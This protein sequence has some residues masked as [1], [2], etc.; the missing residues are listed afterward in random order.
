MKCSG[1]ASRQVASGQVASA[2]AIDAAKYKPAVSPTG[3]QL[4]RNERIAKRIFRMARFPFGASNVLSLAR[5]VNRRRRYLPGRASPAGVAA[6]RRVTC[7]VFGRGGESSEIGGRRSSRSS[8][9]GYIRPGR[10]VGRATKTVVQN[11]LPRQKSPTQRLW[12]AFLIIGQK[13]T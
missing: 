3:H 10:A 13:V 4:R 2:G 11:P 1:I 7:V 8:A 9:A 6:D 5:S 12:L